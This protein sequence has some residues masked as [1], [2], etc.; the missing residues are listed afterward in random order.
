M[1]QAGIPRLRH[2]AKCATFMRDP[3]QAKLACASIDALDS[4]VRGN[5]EGGENV[6]ITCVIASFLS[7]GAA[8]RH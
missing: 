5:D 6:I 3:G 8:A 1:T 2:P 4:R 7:G